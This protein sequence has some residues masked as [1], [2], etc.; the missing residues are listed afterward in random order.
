M[1]AILRMSIRILLARFGW[2]LGRHCSQHGIKLREHVVCCGLLM[3]AG[4]AVGIREGLCLVFD[5]TVAAAEAE[6]SP[7]V[8]ESLT[9][10]YR[11]FQSLIVLLVGTLQPW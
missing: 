2:K 7:A 3:M 1:M 9:V 8:G 5:L 6:I 4:P 10:F 11:G